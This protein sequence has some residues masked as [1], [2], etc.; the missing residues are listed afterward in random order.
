MKK[1]FI[2]LLVVCIP[3]V[4][5]MAQK[6]SLGIFDAQTEVGN[7]KKGMCKYDAQSQEYIITGSGTNIWATHD[8]FQFLYKKMSGDFMLT[9]NAAF[10]GKGVEEHRKWGWMV[11]RS[12]DTSSPHVNA[13]VH[14]DGLTSLQFRRTAGAITEEQKSTITHADV[15]RL[16]RKGNRYYMS[17]AKN[18]DLFTI[19][20]LDLD[21][22]NDVYVGL[23]VCSHNNAVAETAVFHNVRITIPAP[24]T[25]VPYRQYLGSQLEIMDVASATSKIIFQSP[26]SIQAPNYMPDGNHLIYNS[27]GL[28]YKFDLKTLTPSVL[29]TGSITGNNNDHVI[30]FDGKMLGISS[31]NKED[32]ASKVYTLPLSGGEPKQITPT[33]PSYLHGWSADGKYLV[34]VGQRNGDYDIYKVPSTGGEEVN[35]TNSKGLDDGC[36]YSRDGKYIYFNSVRNG[37]MQIYR[38][39]PDGSNVEQLTNDALN[40]WFAHPSPDGKWIVFISFGQDVSPSDHPFY[41]H[42]Y[43]RLMPADGGTPK[44]IAYLYG[45]QGTMNTPCWAPD[46]KKIAF[47]SNSN[48][49]SEVYPVEKK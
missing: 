1:I 7:A 37:L 31:N 47:I 39:K 17:V 10:V 41:K 45:G 44:V 42:V 24:S 12:L 3:A 21:L 48:L 9:T 5:L 14:G 38:M 22:G 35:L 43:I 6:S 18:G 40:N 4:R 30:S 11:R 16:E 8:E 20:S 25:L 32:N 33:G 2:I 23:F 46:S 27:D 15:V 34:F 49:L 36:E 28:I 29:N 19:D 13:V 26:R